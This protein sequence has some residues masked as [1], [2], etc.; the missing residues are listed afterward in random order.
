MR[1]IQTVT[2]SILAL[3]VLPPLQQATITLSLS[4]TTLLLIILALGGYIGWMRGI[5]AVYTVALF[6]IIAYLL[7]VQS[8][9]F[10][11]LINRVWTNIP[12]V[13]ALF[14][15]QEPGP[16]LDPLIDTDA[17]VPLIFRIV[18]FIALVAAAG[19]YNRKAQW[20]GIKKVSPLADFL[21]ALAGAFTALIWT[22]AA[23]VFW[24]EGTGT[25][26]TG[27]GPVGNFLAAIPD[28]GFLILPFTVVFFLVTLFLVALNF[29]K[30]LKP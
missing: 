1:D 12:R 20:Y 5:R 26:V 8:G 6:S 10:V 14:L 24:R 11:D 18:L 7:T 30:L 16:P 22:T 15:G 17:R 9:W 2:N 25:I 13:V 21:G 4:G 3:P 28:V 27:G 23:T 29:P 19:F